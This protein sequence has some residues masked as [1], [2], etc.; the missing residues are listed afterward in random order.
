MRILPRT[1]LAVFLLIGPAAGTALAVTTT[2]LVDLMKAGLS[3]DVLIA[4]IETD[5]STFQLSA[6]DILALHKAGLSNAVI[7]AM[8]KTVLVRARPARPNA[9]EPAGA[10]PSPIVQEQVVQ[11]VGLT[12]SAGVINA[13]QTVAQNVTASPAVRPVVPYAIPIYVRPRVEE[14]PAPPQYWGWNGQRRP[15]TWPDAPQPD[16]TPSKTVTP[17]KKIGGS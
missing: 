2:Q 17:A 15:D 3:D 14:R 4:L 5:G 12:P 10:E 13:V 16:P 7:L 8:Q 9:A 11:P 6:T 1:V